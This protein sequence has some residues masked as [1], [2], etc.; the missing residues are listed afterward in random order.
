MMQSCIG[1]F[2]L[3]GKV[4]AWNKDAANN[5]F[6]NELIF[7]VFCVVPVY[8]IS[9]FI[10]A[11]VLN[12]IE[13]WTGSS[14]MAGVDKV[15]DGGHGQQYHVKSNATGYDIE[16]LG[17]GKQA[18]LLY[19]SVS[20]TWAITADGATMPLVQYDVNGNAHAALPTTAMYAAVK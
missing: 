10:D 1:S 3:T 13:F 14:P 2:A 17:T 5:K 12:S 16:L 9:L 15:I 19:D 6:V 7:L 8:E 20:R 4:H 18:Q 11:I